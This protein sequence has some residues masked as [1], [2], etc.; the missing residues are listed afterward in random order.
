MS[1]YYPLEFALTSTGLMYTQVFNV[2]GFPS[3][4]V[5]LGFDKNGLPIGIQV[6][7]GPFQDKLCIAVAKELSKIGGWVPPS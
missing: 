3:T 7:A 6:I 5:P 1:A 2:F 4:A